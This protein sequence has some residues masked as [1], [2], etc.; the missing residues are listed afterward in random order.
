ML[1]TFYSRTFFRPRYTTARLFRWS[2]PI[3]GTLVKYYG[4]PITPQTKVDYDFFHSHRSRL[5]LHSVGCVCVR[6]WDFSCVFY[7]ND[8]RKREEKL[9]SVCVFLYVY[10]TYVYVLYAC[11]LAFVYVFMCESPG[12]R[13]GK[14]LH[15]PNLNIELGARVITLDANAK[16]PF[17]LYPLYLLPFSPF[18]YIWKETSHSLPFLD[19]CFF[20]PPCFLSPLFFLFPFFVSSF[21]FLLFIFLFFKLIFLSL[22]FSL[23][24]PTSQSRIQCAFPFSIGHRP[25]YRSFAIANK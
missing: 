18:V 13:R 3:R 11:M 25:I 10:T 22:T 14:D 19:R 1:G 7:T 24:L 6:M 20:L 12:K 17:S 23:H 21:L 2:V 4:R 15:R 16:P 9:K 8:R 5:L